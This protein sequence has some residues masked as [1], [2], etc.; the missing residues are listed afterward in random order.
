MRIDIFDADEFVEI[1][2]LKEVTSPI[3][4]QRGDIPDPQGL[5]SNEIFGFTI[6]DRKETFAYC[7]LYGHFFHPH[8]YKIMKRFF[9]NI[10]NIIN[11]SYH[12][13]ISK[14][15]I[16][17]RDEY[18]GET[19]IEFIYDNWEKIDWEKS[20]DGGMRNERIDLIKKA[21]KTEI[22]WTK[23]P[24]IPAFYRDVKSNSHGGG[25]T[26]EL[27]TFYQKI[28]RYG[29]MLKERNLFDFSFHNLNYNMQNALVDIYDYF[30]QKIEKKT[31]LIRKYLMGKS[32]DYCTRTVISGPTFH[33]NSA[34]EMIIDF[35]HCGIP[36]S[37][38]I[39]LAYPFMLRWVK[40]FFEQNVFNLQSLPVVVNGKITE[41]ELRLK[42][43]E[44]YFSDKFFTKKF[45]QYVR[46]PESRFEVVTVPLETGKMMPLTFTGRKLM[47]GTSDELA[48]IINRPMTWTDIFYMAAVDSCQ[49]KHVMVTRYPVSDV[50]GV[51]M[52]K[53]RVISTQ[54]TE[55]MQYG[56]K[57]YDHYP[58]I[59]VTKSPEDIAASFIDSCQFSNSYLK[60]INGDYDGDQTTMKIIWSQDANK[61]CAELREQKQF[62]LNMTGGMIRV[63]GNEA[64]QTFYTMTKE[65]K[66][67]KH[68][69]LSSVETVD[70]LKMHRQ[71]LT[72][73]K[74][75]ELFGICYDAET[76]TQKTPRFHCS[77]KLTIP[78]GTYGN[79][80][81]PIV[82]TVGRYIFN[83]IL[84]EGTPIQ[85][86][87]GYVNS[88]ME[89]KA[90]GKV[91][92][93]ISDGVLTDTISV[94]DCKKYI[95]RRDWL[96]FQFHSIITSS[97]TPEVIQSLPEVVKLREEL[98]KKY[99][100]ELDSHDAKTMSLIEDQL[101]KKTMDILKDNPGLDLYISGARGSVGNNMKNMFMCRGAVKNPLTDDWDI[102]KSSLNDGIRQEDVPSCSNII[103]AGAYPK[104]VA[105][106]VSGYISKQ[107]L[108]ECQTEVADP[109]PNS[110]CGTKRGI[111]LLL[112]SDTA[113]KYIYRYIVVN[114]QLVMLTKNNIGSY[115]GKVIELRSPM[116]C[117]MTNSGCLCGHCVG[118]FPYMFGNLNIGLSASKAGTTLTNLGMKKF[119]NNV[120]KY[121]TLNPSE[122]LI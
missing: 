20:E 1:N 97:F 23:L 121:K 82:T 3:M 7:N 102:V 61:E 34:E 49:D 106:Q 71:D 98:Y 79:N 78:K 43:P 4:F 66:Q 118:K 103:L 54:Q 18:D 110:D 32:V 96:G 12:Y 72:F 30:K 39:S 81:E 6:K 99:E 28:L 122:M 52:G 21:K 85:Q 58:C 19:G 114:H 13:K 17:I 115:I 116:A 69:I 94:D 33:A 26:I 104:S 10:E 37:Q 101:I 77:D 11:G 65:F 76:K 8:I 120:I 60:G 50:Y 55:I 74:L 86:I 25:E 64:S 47:K 31:G 22:F 111:K 119:H 75:T 2:H 107:L 113:N 51:F 108:A 29:V 67:G 93:K 73:D 88:T 27:N 90:F 59:D 105:T 40:N 5:I 109:D 44:S 117:L 36:I 57:K 24:I 89:D 87:V 38:C 80:Q 46:D 56:T 112:T 35:D 100:K 70:L 9:R 48:S 15:G 84:Y 14:D 63:I 45:N 83:A 16:L 62:V 68:K 53:I 42:N 92:G 95:D 41:Q 91:E